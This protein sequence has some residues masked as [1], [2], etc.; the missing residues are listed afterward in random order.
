MLEVLVATLILVLGIIPVYNLMTVQSGQA[1]FSRDREFAASLAGRVLAR[2]RSLPAA[3]IAALRSDDARRGAFLE[4]DPILH[5]AL[6]DKTRSD[7]PPELATWQADLERCQ[8]R[9]ETLLTL[10]PLDGGAD[11]GPFRAVVEIRW[12]ER[13]AVDADQKKRSF[14]LG[15]VIGVPWYATGKAPAAN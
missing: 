11:T 15:Q 1:R 12:D 7:L 6:D 3:E 4:S 13:V 5:P 9:F 10:E 14:F 2:L 8:G